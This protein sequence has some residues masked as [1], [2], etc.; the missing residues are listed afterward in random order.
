MEAQIARWVPPH[1]L[2]ARDGQDTRGA[3]RRGFRRS[4]AGE[5]TR[6]TWHGRP[7]PAVEGAAPPHWGV[8]AAPGHRAEK[9]QYPHGGRNAVSQTITNVRLPATANRG[10]H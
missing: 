5:A 7:A 8:G 9:D 3:S 2:V 1:C 10:E 6:R 4:L